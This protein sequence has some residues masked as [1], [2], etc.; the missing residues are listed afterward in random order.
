M[1]IN[2]NKLHYSGCCI[3][4]G[5]G[6]GLAVCPALGLPGWGGGRG[7]HHCNCLEAKCLSSPW[8]SVN[9]SLTDGSL[10]P[11][12]A[13]APDDRPLPTTAR[14]SNKTVRA[15]ARICFLSCCF[16]VLQLE[17]RTPEPHCLRFSC[18]RSGLTCVILGELFSLFLSLF[19][20]HNYLFIG[21]FIYCVW[22]TVDP[23]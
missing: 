13:G 8:N 6:R 9:P 14:F 2:K 23:R 18:V 16:A 11:Q 20:K 12:Y 17:L 1:D 5:V 10:S 3:I 22:T 7:W 4:S 15:P 19:L 21:F